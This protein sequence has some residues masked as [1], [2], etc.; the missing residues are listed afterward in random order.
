VQF[1]AAPICL[2]A[3]LGAAVLVAAVRS[4]THQRRTVFSAAAVLAVCGV[5]I[6]LFDL[7]HPY[8]HHV[9]VVHR[10]FAQWFWTSHLSAGDVAFLPPPQGTTT[11]SS[12][13]YCAFRCLQRIY[14]RPTAK[15]ASAERPILCI[16]YSTTGDQID[17]PA[18]AMALGQMHSQLYFQGQRRFSVNL[19]N[20][21][22][23][24]VFGEYEVYQFA[25]PVD[26]N[27]ARAP[28]A[29]SLAPRR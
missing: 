15:A 13:G 27:I 20:S 8:K 5:G 2:T 4:A 17:A 1:M 7:V 18:V 26:P 6:T 25:R 3:G 12:G 16:H 10:G 29:R 14:A 23:E 9:D 21:P 19:A 11:A 24:T 28:A 22:R